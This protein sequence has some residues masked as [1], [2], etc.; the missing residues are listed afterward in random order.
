MEIQDLG[1]GDLKELVRINNLA[2][3][4]VNELD[5]GS[6][7]DIIA[8]ASFAIKVLQGGKFAGFLLGLEP[9][10]A[11]ASLNYRWFCDRYDQFAYVDRIVVSEECRGSGVGQALYEALM[12]FCRARSIPRITC[13]VNIEPPNPGSLAFH[14]QF[15]FVSAG[16][17]RTEGGAKEVDLLV[18]ELNDNSHK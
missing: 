11:Y 10:Q 15:G 17:Q 9:G 2:L 1:Q 3:P 18:L 13:E 8:Q 6:A 14:H 4:H 7:A 16:T 5:E 12:S